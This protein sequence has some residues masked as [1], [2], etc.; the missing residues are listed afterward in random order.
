MVFD[1]YKMT[2]TK[3]YHFEDPIRKIVEFKLG[4]TSYLVVMSFEDFVLLI[5]LVD[6][7]Y[8][9]IIGHKSYVSNS[10]VEKTPEPIIITCG[11]DHRIGII[12][13][14]KINPSLWK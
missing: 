1:L 10:I 12:R 9:K 13:F 6:N 2:N 14:Q 8:C 3:N 5:N 7:T 4:L 11:M